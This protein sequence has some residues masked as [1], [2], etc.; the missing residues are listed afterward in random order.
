M[1]TTR[2]SAIELV[3]KQQSAHGIG[4]AP[5]IDPAA[6]FAWHSGKEIGEQH[7]IPSPGLEPGQSGDFGIEHG[8]GLSLGH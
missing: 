1:S 5:E 8:I 7:S 6:E 2:M 3:T 4:K